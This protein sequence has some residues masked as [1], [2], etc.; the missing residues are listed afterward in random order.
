MSL[1][2]TTTTTTTTTTT[3]TTATTILR[4][5]KIIMD[6]VLEW[7]S[8][9]VTSL[10][11]IVFHEILRHKDETICIPRLSHVSRDKIHIEKIWEILIYE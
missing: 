1:K 6:E 2:I 3:A 9:L 5:C 10:D 8:Y 4:R 7:Q 11:E